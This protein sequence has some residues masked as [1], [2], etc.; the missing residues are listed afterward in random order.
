MEKS[1]KIYIVSIGIIILIS[2]LLTSYLFPDLVRGKIIIIHDSLIFSSKYDIWNKSFILQNPFYYGLSQLQVVGPAQFLFMGII[3]GIFSF[4]QL[5]FGNI[6]GL[7][8][9][10]I[11]TYILT[12]AFFGFLGIYNLFKIDK[13]KTSK[14]HIFCIVLLTLLYFFNPFNTININNGI[15]FSLSYL[16]YGS[17]PLFLYYLL[18]LIHNKLTSKDS[19]FFLIHIFF[20]VSI[21]TYTI[22]VIIASFILILTNTK[23]IKWKNFI[24]QSFVLVGF[25]IL[26]TL[27]ITIPFILQSLTPNFINSYLSNSTNS[28]IQRGILTPLIGIFHWPLYSLWTPRSLYTFATYYNSFIFALA[29]ISMYIIIIFLFIKNKNIRNNLLP[30]IIIL[31]LAIFFVKGSNPPFG[32][33]YTYLV[34]NI[35]IFGAVRSPDNKFSVLI[36]VS[37]CIILLLNLIEFKKYKYYI[38]GYIGVLILIFSYPF[39]TKEVILSQDDYPNSGSYVFNIIQEYT[40]VVNYV[41]NDRDLYKVLS[42]PESGGYRAYDINQKLFIGRDVISTLMRESIVSYDPTQDEV[43]K[44]FVLENKDINSLKYT[45]I[46]YILIRK[47]LFDKKEDIDKMFKLVEATES[48]KIIDNQYLTLYKVPEDIFK[49]KIIIDDDVP[50]SF[51]KINITQYEVSIKNLKNNTELNFLEGFDKQYKLYLNEYSNVERFNDTN[52]K[53]FTGRDLSVL[54]DK[55]VFEDSHQLAY[56]YANQWTIDPEYIKTNFDKS[57][58]KENPDG[59]ID[60]ELTLYFKPQSYFYLGIII[61]GTT[62]ILCL[63]YLGYTFYRK[64]G[65]KLSPNPLEDGNRTS[66]PSS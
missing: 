1:K 66:T 44:Q 54:V 29:S 31:L 3:Y 39:F 24:L 15:F 57:Y 19:V 2:F 50:Y 33:V 6:T 20:I 40:D 51:N 16:S 63:G 49:P 32:D 42:L 47:D 61:S 52:F 13:E 55:P 18:K 17:I 12:C 23:I 64:R 48:Q 10:C 8:Y 30:Y 45:N 59:S 21:T 46:K 43:L 11:Q 65:G 35:S 9:F 36:P 56:D 60:I 37:F 26:L 41:N 62:L 58:Y 4:L 22:P 27:P 53:Y 5:S 25:T 7:I 34:N 14:Y 38:F 28:L